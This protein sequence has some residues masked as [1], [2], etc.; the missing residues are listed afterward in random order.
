MAVRSETHTVHTLYI[1]VPDDVIGKMNT[2]DDVRIVLNSRDGM[3]RP[4]ALSFTN[5][6]ILQ[7]EA[8]R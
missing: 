3:T 8:R 7:G 1:D 4:M 5:A 6:R 2:G